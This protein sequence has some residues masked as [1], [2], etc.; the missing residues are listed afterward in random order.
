V[1]ISAAISSHA[2]SQEPNLT[3]AR[4]ILGQASTLVPDIPEPQR[5]S[6]ASNIANAQVRA[7]DLVGALSTVRSLK[8]PQ[9]FA[10][11]MG[12]IAYVLDS[13]GD[14]PAALQVISDAPAGQS[15]DLSYEHIAQSHADKGDFSSAMRI[16]HLIQNAPGRSVETL[17]RVAQLQWKSGDHAGADQVWADALAVAQQAR[18]QDPNLAMLLVGIATSRAQVGESAAAYATLDEFSRIIEQRHPADQG[19]LSTLAMGYAGIG[20]TTS[21][22]HTVETLAPGSNRDICLMTISSQLMKND[23]VADAE[24]IASRISDPQLKAH[25][26]QEIAISESGSGRPASAIETADKIPNLAGRAEALAY[27]ALE[28][29]QK[30]DPA[31]GDTLRRAVA[32]ATQATPKPPDHVFAAI[33]VTEAMLGDFDTAEQTVRPLSCDA[34]PWA[35][36]NIAAMMANAGDLSGAVEVAA[37][38]E[39]PHSKAYALLGS[40]NGILDR[41]RSTAESKAH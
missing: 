20:D 36:W 18:K 14:L 28:Q 15:R 7:G 32:A 6:V 33:A 3:Q 27:L 11:G 2:A 34:R 37:Q 38:E 4:E 24:E 13:S 19:L 5:M 41:L 21:A 16:A 17:T 8:K 40:A 39:D 10:F 23:D 26:F 12:I 1:V 31:T 25:A 30:G 29:A 35:W 22:L 9:D